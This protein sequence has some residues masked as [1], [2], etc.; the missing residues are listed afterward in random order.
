MKKTTTTRKSNRRPSRERKDPNGVQN[1]LSAR[2]SK[3]GSGKRA[4][5]LDMNTTLDQ[6]TNEA[7]KPATVEAP[8]NS[9]AEFTRGQLGKAKR[10]FA[11]AGQ[12]DA[13]EE[14]RKK[15]LAGMNEANVAIMKFSSSRLAKVIK[16]EVT[17]SELQK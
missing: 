3:T 14:V 17:V 13:G 6:P 1:Q 12:P 16:G 15:W 7:T 8:K 9:K 5:K 4:K 11:K 2:R 10:A